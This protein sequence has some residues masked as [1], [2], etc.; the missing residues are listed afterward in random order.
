MEKTMDKHEM[1]AQLEIWKR[2]AR[3]NE[4]RVRLLQDERESKPY[5][6]NRRQ[7]KELRTLLRG[8]QVDA[9]H[10]VEITAEDFLD[11]AGRLDYGRVLGWLDMVGAKLKP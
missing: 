10:L 4:R 6:L 3:I 1:A 5:G 8:H 2:F 9:A 7:A 11:M